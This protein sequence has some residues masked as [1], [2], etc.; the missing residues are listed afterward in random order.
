MCSSTA[1]NWCIEICNL[2]LLFRSEFIRLPLAEVFDRLSIGFGKC[3]SFPGT[4]IAI[5]G[6]HIPITNLPDSANRFINRKG[7]SSLNFLVAADCDFK[8]RYVF[9]GTF[10]SS[11]DS[12]VFQA[13]SLEKWAIEN[14][15][16]A[17]DYHILGDAAYPREHILKVLLKES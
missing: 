5:D 7:T 9:G 15:E 16:T 8:M 4:I 13:L 17:P 11:H 6:S 14:L 3:S 12:F 1:P 10:G 2:I